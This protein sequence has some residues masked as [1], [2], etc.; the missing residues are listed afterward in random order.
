MRKITSISLRILL[1]GA[2]VAW[3]ATQAGIESVLSQ[4]QQT[5]ILPLAFAFGAIAS[6]VAFR[7]LNWKMLLEATSSA[8]K[9]VYRALLSIYLA[10]GLVGMFVPS[11]AGIDVVRAGVT[12]RTFGGHF[13][14][15]AA[16]VVMQNA[17]SFFVACLLGLLG[18]F[19]HY[20]Q[21]DLPQ[22]LVPVAVI[23][24][25]VSIGILGL[26]TIL[27][28]R[29]GLVLLAVRRLGRR[30]FRLR[31]AL[32]RFLDAFFVFERAHARP[33]PILLASA[34][35]LLSQ[36]CA[37]ALLGAALGIT[38]PAGAWMLLPSVIAIAALLPASFLGFG[39]IQAA[40]VYILTVCGV[41]LADSVA[42]ATLIA[43]AN[44]TFRTATGG[45]AMVLW[46]ARLTSSVEGQI[47][48]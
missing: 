43:L 6:E 39:A 31:R 30:W 44:I 48:R 7:V 5:E 37:Y 29:R 16:S 28:V 23:L 10:T 41:P 47:P 3:L 2:V 13:A 38:L 20:L 45:V 9:I 19:I 24:A 35:A 46:P 25:G 14:A 40:N 26:Y 33:G 4:L 27:R 12:Q 22:E 17:V 21:A 32:R 11:S 36:S 18:M 8:K 42:L 15:H 1:A 34:A